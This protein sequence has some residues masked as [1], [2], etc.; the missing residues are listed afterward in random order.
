MARTKKRSKSSL[1]LI[2]AIVIAIAGWYVYDNHWDTPPPLPQDSVTVHFIDVGQGDAVLI[3]AQGQYMLIDGGERGSENTVI[4]YLRQLG[5]DRLDY[6]V[7]TH[8][9]SDHI[10]GLAN[11]IIDAFPVGTFIQPQLSEAHDTRTYE[12]F[13]LAVQRNIEEHGGAAR[14]ARVGEV[15]TLGDAQLTVL[16][17][18]SEDRRQL[19][20]SSVVLRL[21][22][23]R[24]SALFA[25]DAERPAERALANTYGER[26]NVCLFMA[27]HHG[28]N[29]SSH[30]EI[31]YYAQPRYVVISVGSYNTHGHPHPAVMERLR[32]TNATIYRT[33]IYG[34]IVMISDGVSFRRNTVERMLRPQN[35]ELN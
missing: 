14:Y 21:E 16:G 30:P 26:L 29:S 33:D 11:G 5:I 19:N 12:R 10:G 7:A 23:G 31:L 13:L 18:L 32:G 6:I 15:I 8:P 9:H 34:T 27:P 2:A 4:N 17:P 24:A 1:C 25:G 20:N 22:H 28:S 3:A 35:T